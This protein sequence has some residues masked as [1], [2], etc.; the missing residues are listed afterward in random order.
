LEDQQK[1]TEKE[2]L[3]YPLLAD[4]EKKIAKAYGVL[5]P[6][7]FANRATFVIDK[8]GFIR[9]IYPNAN[10]QK[11]AEEVLDFVKNNLKEK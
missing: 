6:R 3:S 5:S 4:P 1:F 9:R 11:N 10:A 2:Q 8:K 7:G